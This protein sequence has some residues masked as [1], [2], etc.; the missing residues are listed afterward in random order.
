MIELLLDA[1]VSLGS[2]EV[3]N[4]LTSVG[5]SAVKKFRESQAW[6]KLIVGTGEFF[7]KNEQEENSFFEDLELVLSRENLTQIAK[8]L[9]SD[10]G[11]ELKHRL[12][13][14][15]MKLMNKYEIPYEVAETYTIKIIYAVLEQLKTIAPDKYEHYFL[16]E[17]KEEQE[18][19]FLE[20]QNRIDKMSYELAIYNREQVAI[21]S[22]GQMDI[23]LRRKTQNPSI[24]IE[25][26]IVDDEHFQDEFENQR[27]EELAFVRG[28]SREETIYCVLNELWRLNDKRPI[29][30]I[31][32]IESWNKLHVLENEGNVYIPW[33]YAEEIVAIENNTNIFV[34]DEN[35]PVFN[36]K[37][38]EL[39][40]RTRDTY[41]IKKKIGNGG[42]GVVF[43]ADII[44]GGDSLPPKKD[45]A[46]KFLDVTSNEE[47]KLEKRKLRF[48][49]EIE[50][51]LS[52]QDK[53]SGIIPIYD[54]SV[55]CEEE[56][57]VLWY[58]MPKA[59]K[60]NPQK[61]SVLQKMEQMFALGN[62]IRQLHKLGFVHRD[63]KPVPLFSRISD[64][65]GN[66][67]KRIRL[68]TNY[69]IKMVKLTV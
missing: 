47:K 54:T 1:I 41:L 34:I 29:Y 33:F 68:N 64:G 6:K 15:L 2:T 37:I 11:Y 20:L 18:S 65:L 27:Y 38:L 17:W 21:A 3:Q 10:E 4:V 48:R 23:E 12:Y 49:K 36:K 26:F 25:F 67:Y 58:L 52:F 7:I 44:E 19:S 24:G 61:F 50:T 22:S 16:Q 60:Y 55:Y 30:I 13:N 66:G 5:E 8:E 39:R 43:V 62:C 53:V 51:V 9:K 31:K 69:L 56:P 46:I 57:D 40:P 63:I 14:S 32:N 59:E 28:R 45:Y 42:N 35:T